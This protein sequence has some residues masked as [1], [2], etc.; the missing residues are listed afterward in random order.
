MFMKKGARI[1]VMASGNGTNAEAIFNYFRN[2]PLIEVVLL[3]CNNPEAQVL[4]RA[5]KFGIPTSIVGRNEFNDEVFMLGLLN[6]KD[7]THLV[8]AG[9]LWLI[10]AY[11]VRA[12]PEKIVNIHPSLLPKFGGKGMFGMKVHEAIKKAGE[13][14]TGITIHLVNEK[15]DDGRVLFQTTCTVTNDDTPE[16]IAA[17]V[18]QLEHDSY[19]KVIED[20]IKRQG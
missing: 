4:N 8:L 5:K 6:S 2:H 13:R 17:K 11:L 20:W 19:P 12:F 9:F 14:Q 1:V 15:Y 16:Q 7:A 10:P 3:V 18:H